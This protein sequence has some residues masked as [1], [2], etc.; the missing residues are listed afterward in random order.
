MSYLRR[1]ALIVPT[2]LLAAWLPVSSGAAHAAAPLTTMHPG[3][4]PALPAGA[5]GPPVGFTLTSVRVSH[6]TAST[7]TAPQQ[8]AAELCQAQLIT[9]TAAPTVPTGISAASC[10]L[11]CGASGCYSGWYCEYD[12]SEMCSIYGCWAWHSQVDG[13]FAY[14]NS[15]QVWTNGAYG[16]W[17]DF[18]TGNSGGLGYSVSITN[19]AVWNNG[20]GG[21]KNYMNA[22]NDI[23]VSWIYN[24]NPLSASY[25][26]RI[27]VDVH[28]SAWVTMS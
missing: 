24:G 27:N 12:S 20:G 15:S 13:I 4:V 2:M 6:V 7:C 22:G 23:T 16:T 26:Q 21:G 18:G 3:G 10:T 5:A 11:A 1:L 17:F 9:T 28:G 25:W 8:E 19:K 14:N